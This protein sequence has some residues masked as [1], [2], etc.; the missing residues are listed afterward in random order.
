MVSRRSPTW[1][2]WASDPDAPDQRVLRPN[3]VRLTMV[4]MRL[5][6][7]AWPCTAMAASS[8]CPVAGPWVAVVVRGEAV[9]VESAACGAPCG[10][11][12]Q[13]WVPVSTYLIVESF[14]SLMDAGIREGVDGAA[15]ASEA[16]A[17]DGSAVVPALQRLGIDEIERCVGRH[18]MH[19]FRRKA[20][21]STELAADSSSRLIDGAR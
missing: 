17:R 15:A 11:R 20:H 16:R 7:G 6:S 14:E 21:G 9:V 10:L 4:S 18:L 13:G 5:N 12:V 2:R 3:E 19:P 1:L 8:S